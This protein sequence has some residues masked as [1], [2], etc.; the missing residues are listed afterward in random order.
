MTARDSDELSINI[1]EN[2]YCCEITCSDQFIDDRGLVRLY[3]L[4]LYNKQPWNASAEGESSRVDGISE[5]YDE[6]LHLKMLI[7]ELQLYPVHLWDVV[8]DYLYG[9]T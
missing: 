5:S 6:V 1:S 9:V 7:D 8:E 3:G 4:V 2:A